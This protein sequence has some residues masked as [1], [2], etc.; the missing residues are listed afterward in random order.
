MGLETSLPYHPKCLKGLFGKPRIPSLPFGASDI[1][2]QVVKTKARMSISGVQIKLSVRVNPD[3]W[4]LETV[5]EGGT[6]ILKP[7][8]SQYPEL[9][10]NENLCMNIA[11][12]LRHSVPPHGLF[13]MAD[14]SLCYL[15]KR[16]DRL[17]DGT[18][19]QKESIFQIIGAEDK[20]LGSLEQVGKTILKYA[21]N[22]GLDAIDFFERVLLCFL[23][24][25]GD[26]HLKN[27]ALLTSMNGRIAIAPC[28]D[29]VSSQI[30]IA[31]ESDSALTANGKKN[32]L[33][34]SDF[35]ALASVLKIDPKAVSISFRNLL[36]VKKRIL[37]MCASS[38]VSASMRQK[39]T[40]IIESRY[41]RLELQ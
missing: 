18:K 36:G 41:T 5:A 9:P 31:E 23:I 39:L 24:G 17:D 35:E 38:A 14:G 22:S 3:T 25:N 1:R 8:P 11:G 37:E 10:Q 15:I 2:E 21:A 12:E 6:H 16:F 7:E 13:S 4:E 27:W 20:Y 30:Y 33:S 28:Y 32:R 40:D 34:I 26:M 19:L 29:F